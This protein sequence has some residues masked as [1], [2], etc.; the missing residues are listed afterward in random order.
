MDLSTSYLDIK[1][2]FAALGLLFSVLTSSLG[3]VKYLESRRERGDKEL[4]DRIDAL[5]DHLNEYAKNCLQRRDVE[6]YL[7][8]VLEQQKEINSRVDE[9]Y[10]L[11]VTSI[12]RA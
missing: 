2:I 3:A 6:A 1:S 11:L 10:K 7:Q 5:H 12:A 8:S 4:H 9:V